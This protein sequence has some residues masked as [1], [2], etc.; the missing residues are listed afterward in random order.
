M[1]AADGVLFVAATF[2]SNFDPINF[3][4]DG[5]SDSLLCFSFAVLHPLP[6][7]LSPLYRLPDFGEAAAAATEAVNFSFVFIGSGR[8]REERRG[9]GLSF[10]SVVFRD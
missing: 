3:P 5:R 10:P 6:P 4:S 2:L 9:R 7:S 8:E 1:K